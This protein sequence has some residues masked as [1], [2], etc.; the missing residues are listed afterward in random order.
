V[1]PLAFTIA[2][3]AA[4]GIVR[5]WK[6][7]DAR[8]T[9][10]L[11]YY[12]EAWA[13]ARERLPGP[14]GRKSVRWW[15]ERETAQ[16]GV[17]NDVALDPDVGSSIR[18]RLDGLIET[19]VIGWPRERLVRRKG[20]GMEPP[21]QRMRP[22]RSAVVEMRTAATRTFGFFARTGVFVVHR[23]DLA[24]NTHADS[25]LY[26]EYGDAVVKLLDRMASSD[27]DEV[28]DVE[29]LIGG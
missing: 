10:R 25:T 1:L 4:Q 20:F 26:G 29:T 2:T 22:P 17:D 14:P 9:M 15:D 7:G 19:F 18:S 13:V 23:L 24:D 16:D 6:P 28:S 21:F 8:M 27:K 12:S 11:F 5:A 3:L